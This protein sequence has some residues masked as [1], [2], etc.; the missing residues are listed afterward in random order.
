MGRRTDIVERRSLPK[1]LI[2]PSTLPLLYN[3]P[4]LSAAQRTLQFTI[5]TTIPPIVD[6]IA[7]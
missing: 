6:V 1:H 4:Y 5:G 3:L 2:S 7:V